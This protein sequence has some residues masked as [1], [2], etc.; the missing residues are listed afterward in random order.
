MDSILSADNAEWMPPFSLCAE[1]QGLPDYAGERLWQR[2]ADGHRAYANAT[3]LSLRGGRKVEH[4]L[5]NLDIPDGWLLDGEL[6]VPD[7]DVGDV[8]SALAAKRWKTLYFEPF[9]V[10]VAGDRPRIHVADYQTRWNVIS[11]RWP[12]SVVEVLAHPG[13]PMPPV[14]DHWEGVVGKLLNVPW[15]SGRSTNALKWK[16]TGELTAVIVGFEEGSG[17]WRGQVGKVVFGL[18]S[19][20]VVVPVGYAGGLSDAERAA[21]TA[22]PEQYVGRQCVIRHYGMNKLKLRNPVFVSVV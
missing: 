7:G 6:I 3:H 21:F 10:L 14:P 12:D 20:D 16:R 11:E 18:P 17:S 22:H 19:G 9:D 1:L 5:V 8:A 4:S 15:R 13:E 2:K